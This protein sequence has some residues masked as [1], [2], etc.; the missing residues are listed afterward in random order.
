M[1]GRLK[2]CW[3]YD[4]R[5]DR[6]LEAMLSVFN[7]AGPWE[8]ELRESAWYGDY[9]NTQPIKGLRVR[10]HKYPQAGEAGMFTGL[11]DE[12]FSVLV[13]RKAETLI[14]QCEVDQIL[15]DLLNRVDAADITAI[16][17]YD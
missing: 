8:W 12:G 5:C 11:R 6:S 15:L 1:E 9:L 13:K 10:I 14:T 2:S 4:F 17:P 3:A 7:E 16:E